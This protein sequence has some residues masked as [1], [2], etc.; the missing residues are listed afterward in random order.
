MNAVTARCYWVEIKYH[1]YGGESENKVHPLQP[2]V[3]LPQW[4]VFTLVFSSAADGSNYT[5]AK[6]HETGSGDWQVTGSPAKPTGRF[7]RGRV[8]S[9]PL[10][11]LK[12][13]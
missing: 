4:H 9:R 6:G 1:I 13:S 8:I 7:R 3:H 2:S 10:G 5:T 11:V 12:Q